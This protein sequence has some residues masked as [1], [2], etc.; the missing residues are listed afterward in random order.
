MTCFVSHFS[1]AKYEEI[2]V[3]KALKVLNNMKADDHIDIKLIDSEG[4]IHIK[5][6]KVIKKEEKVIDKSSLKIGDFDL[7]PIKNLKDKSVPVLSE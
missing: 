1:Y 7:F 2:D 5:R 4:K 3:E 6:V